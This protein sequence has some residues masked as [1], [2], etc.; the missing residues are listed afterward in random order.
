MTLPQPDPENFWAF[1]PGQTR[2]VA[3]TP[4]SLLSCRLDSINDK[5][6]ATGT[7]TL[8]GKCIQGEFFLD[9]PVSVARDLNGVTMVTMTLRRIDHG[10]AYFQVTAHPEMKVGTIQ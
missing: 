9:L 3:H 1:Q 5:G 2:L 4:D 10:T 7:I 6:A 8:G